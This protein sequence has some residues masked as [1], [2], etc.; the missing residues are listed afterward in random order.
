MVINHVNVPFKIDNSA[1]RLIH[2]YAQLANTMNGQD[3]ENL[4]DID[5]EFAEILDGADRMLEDKKKLCR[6][7]GDLSQE[8]ASRLPESIPSQSIETASFLRNESKTWNLISSLF[9]RQTHYEDNVALQEH[10]LV[11]RWL[12]D[13]APKL[14]P[15]TY[16]KKEWKRSGVSSFE[17]RSRKINGNTKTQTM[18]EIDDDG[19]QR[20]KRRL[21][22]QDSDSNRQIT[23]S[24]FNFVRRGQIKEAIKMCD[25]CDEPWQS[26]GLY[27]YLEH[28][29]RMTDAAGVLRVK[30]LSSLEATARNLWRTSCSQIAKDSNSDLYERATY[31]ALCG[32]VEN[33]LPACSTWEDT[34][35]AYYN[36]LVENLL[37]DIMVS[38]SGSANDI[39]P[40]EII[41]SSAQ[42]KDSNADRSTQAFHYCQAMIITNR[43][44]ELI[45]ALHNA[46]VLKKT[47]NELLLVTD[48]NLRHHLLRFVTLLILYLSSISAYT[49]TAESDAIICEYIKCHSQSDNGLKAQ[50][51]ALY[52]SKL[53]SAEIQANTYAMYLQRKYNTRYVHI[54]SALADDGNLDFDGDRGERELLI[55]VGQHHQLDVHRILWNLYQKEAPTKLK[56]SEPVDPSIVRQ[57]R[58]LE[59]L[60]FDERLHTEAIIQS[61]AMIRCFLADGNI[62]A[63]QTVFAYLPSS[64][65]SS[66]LNEQIDD[67]RDL[68]Q[69]VAEMKLDDVLIETCGLFSLWSNLHTKRPTETDSLE[70]LRAY[71]EWAS[72]FEQLSFTLISK[73][74]H[75]LRSR[76]CLN[77]TCLCAKLLCM[78]VPNHLSP[79]SDNPGQMIPNA[80]LRQMY[81]PELV[82][83]L[84]QVLFETQGLLPG[85][86][87][88]SLEISDMVANDDFGINSDFVRAH[89]M[90][91]LVHR[92]RQSSI[93]MLQLQQQQS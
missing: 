42:R 38:G 79:Y 31:A 28:N 84:H 70:G 21:Q 88:K 76:W 34:V 44:D 69:I 5:S 23:K 75:L 67:K 20:Q 90:G 63:A 19:P 85:N 71:Q 53:S 16:D 73:L 61:N 50:L 33:T 37:H 30:S 59:W 91:E 6:K 25:L 72:Q 52:C 45:H 60:T 51:V 22:P 32:D 82:L 35:W 24:L 83:N 41:F 17:E 86:L 68:N 48:N 13:T 77:G 8:R 46:L 74:Q 47:A 36:A 15:T 39:P 65:I 89:R 10:L 66:I 2:L 92:I 62:S 1:N 18:M 80:V 93:K 29:Q 43:L 26:A 4:E 58:S 12:Q 11:L 27:G 78:S 54:M 87:E 49:P 40:E 3:S 55:E 14:Q 64:I 9:N 56:Q 81:V 57:I 7:F